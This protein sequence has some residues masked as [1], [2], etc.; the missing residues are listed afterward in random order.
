MIRLLLA[1][2]PWCSVLETMTYP[3]IRMT[4]IRP[5]LFLLLAVSIVGSVAC[6]TNDPA[7]TPTIPV[8]VVPQ[9]FPFAI[10]SSGVFDRK[11][12][13]YGSDDGQFNVP[14]SVAVASDGSVYVADAVSYTHLRAHET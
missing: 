14:V 8:Q 7:S 1:L 9:I 6:G 13:T 4:N 3:F 11:W 5:L 2:L 10:P 12:G